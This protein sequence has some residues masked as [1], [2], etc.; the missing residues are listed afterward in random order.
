MGHPYTNDHRRKLGAH[1]RQRAALSRGG[2]GSDL[3]HGRVRPSLSCYYQKYAYN[4]P[5]ARWR[6]TADP[7]SKY[8]DKEFDGAYNISLIKQDLPNVRFG[9]IDY[10]TVTRLTTSWF[11]WKC[12]PVPLLPLDQICLNIQQSPD[13]RRRT[14]PGR[15]LRFL[16]HNEI[17]VMQRICINSSRSARGP[18]SL[19]GT[20]PLLPEVTCTSSSP[21]PHTTTCYLRAIQREVCRDIRNLASQDL[22]RRLAHPQV[23]LPRRVGLDRQFAHPGN[24]L[25][26]P[27]EGEETQTACRQAR[28]CPTTTT[29]SQRACSQHACSRHAC[30]HV[31]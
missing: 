12:V 15:V 21:P 17:R 16:R 31:C 13:L 28:E 22:Q 23:A 29:C 9:R 26:G 11:I 7:L 5:I 4:A 19:H 8:V 25:M 3:V 24:A 30:Y 1:G 27:E 18:K 20:V 10:L 2:K 6:A 14:R